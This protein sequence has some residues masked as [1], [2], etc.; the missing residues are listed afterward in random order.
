MLLYKMIDNIFLLSKNNQISLFFCH[1]SC[2]KVLKEIPIGE[3]QPDE[4]VEAEHEAVLLSQLSHPNI[5]KF[6]DKFVDRE[7]FFI[8]TEYCEVS[9]SNLLYQLFSLFH[10]F[11]RA[12]LNNLGPIKKHWKY[13]FLISIKKTNLY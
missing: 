12:H 4:T 3:L 11:I 10:R 8:I 9:F 7:F 2:L 13:F 6:I 1:S 5:V